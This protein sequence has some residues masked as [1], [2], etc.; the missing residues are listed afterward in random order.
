MVEGGCGGGRRH[1]WDENQW[2]RQGDWD[3]LWGWVGKVIH[4]RHIRTGRCLAH[5]GG[6][7]GRVG[8]QIGTVFLFICKFLVN[9]QDPDWMLF[10]YE[11]FSG[12]PVVP[13]IIN[14]LWFPPPPH[15]FA[16]W[17]ILSSLPSLLDHEHP[18]G[19]GLAHIYTDH[20]F[21][22]PDRVMWPGTVYAA[23][24]EWGTEHLKWRPSWKIWDTWWKRA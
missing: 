16:Y 22:A 5:G 10:P 24:S 15:H 1:G 6:I 11:N 12:F 21:L 8:T 20:L 23:W 4:Q 14:T 3:I 19:W 7:V 17:F 13:W 2:R 18:K 9:F